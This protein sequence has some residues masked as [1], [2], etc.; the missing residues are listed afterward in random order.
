[1]IDNTFKTNCYNVFI[2]DIIE[3]IGMNITIQLDFAFFLLQDQPS[4]M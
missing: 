2:A 1:M 3:V 4:Y